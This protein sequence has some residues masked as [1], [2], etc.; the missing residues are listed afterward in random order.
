MYCKHCG[1]EITDDSKFC[2]YCGTNL[3][4]VGLS[5]GS[6]NVSQTNETD[7]ETVEPS[8]NDVIEVSS[9]NAE[10]S[11]SSEPI[12]DKRWEN[13][14]TSINSDDTT[15][16][17][18]SNKAD[19]INSNA[20]ITDSKIM[21]ILGIASGVILW[22]ILGGFGVLLLVGLLFI[23]YMVIMMWMPNGRGIT[24]YC[25]I[26]GITCYLVVKLIINIIKSFRK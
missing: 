11:V 10:Q 5:E 18:K 22:V 23:L 26:L 24:I 13:E 14:T 9:E 21:K 1:K 25:I 8:N 12:V 7:V 19:E 2:R 20:S 17:E 4:D 16:R 15:D 6:S 3:V